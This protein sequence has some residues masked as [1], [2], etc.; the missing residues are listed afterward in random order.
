MTFVRARQSVRPSRGRG[1]WQLP[2]GWATQPGWTAAALG[3]QSLQLVH[4]SLSARFGFWKE[5]FTGCLPDAA[6][7]MATGLVRP[8]SGIC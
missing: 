1:V 6:S 2:S 4:Q 7:L 3:S 8:G 5:R